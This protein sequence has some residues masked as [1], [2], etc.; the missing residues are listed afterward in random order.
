MNKVKK[1]ISYPGTQ[2]LLWTALILITWEVLSRAGVINSY[3]LPSCSDVMVKLYEEIV[4][5]NF[6]LQIWNSF[7]MIIAGFAISTL[8]SGII[9][10]LCVC[11]KVFTSFIKTVCTLMTPLPGVAIMPIIIMIFGIDTRA[12]LVLMLHSVMWPLIINVLGGI[13]LIPKTITEYATNIELSKFRM[14]SD[15]YLFAIMPCVISGLKIGWGR[16]WRALISAE[17][18]FGMIG[19]LGGIG[20]YI[21]TNRA[22]GNMPKVMVGVISVIIIGIIVEYILFGLIEKFTVKRWGMNNE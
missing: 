13:N 3:L 16:S 17:M 6:L 21:Y 7:Y 22:Y 20:Y 10:T 19:N 9:I 1:L 15:V 11:S 4:S 8:L 5:G 2:T 18:V 14:F 12:M